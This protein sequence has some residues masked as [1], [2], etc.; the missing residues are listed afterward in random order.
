MDKQTVT[1]VTE[2]GPEQ[3]QDVTDARV[4]D[5]FVWITSGTEGSVIGVPVSRVRRIVAVPNV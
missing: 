5:G 1:L 3:H 2:N 4:K